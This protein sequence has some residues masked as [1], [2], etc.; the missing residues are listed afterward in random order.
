M[1]LLF[2]L[3]LGLITYFIVQRG[4]ASSTST[5]VWILWLV[6]MTP[7]LAWT[8]WIWVQGEDRAPPLG[9]M[10][11][12]FVFS[13]LLYLYLIQVGRSS[14]PNRE[15]AESEQESKVAPPPAL[16]VEEQRQLEQCFPWS[17]YALH[18]TECKGQVVVCRGQLRTSSDVAYKTVR[19]KIEAHFGD[20]FLIVFQEGFEDKPFFVL[21]PNPQFQAK[22]PQ[23]RLTRPMMALG[24]L[25]LTILT[26]TL[27]GT[28]AFSDLVSPE[29]EENPNLLLENPSLLAPG[30]PYAI[31]LMTILGIHELGHYLMARRYKIKATLPYFI[32]IPFFLGTFGAFIQ[33]RSPIPHRKALFDVGI[34]G[35]LAGL[36]VTIPIFMWGLSQSD[37]I[38]ASENTS[39]FNFDSLNPKA[40]VL[41]A[42]LSK[43]ALGNQLTTDMAVNLHPVAVAGFLGLVITALNLVPVGQLDGGHVVHAMFGQRTAVA[44]GQIS[45]LLVLILAFLHQEFLWWAIFL[46]L[47]PI[48]DEP[49]LN[50]VTELDNVRDFLGLLALVILVMIVLPAPP[51]LIEWFYG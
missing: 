29:V 44:I 40:T 3:L 47:M 7:A 51:T 10:I 32:P 50:D 46:L 31:A 20:R 41:L 6:M 1:T 27:M 28:L 39:M 33:I 23:P 11:A 4:V 9:V 30:L 43:I 49:A 2:L 26:T 24:L 8:V 22:S 5:P 48:A 17:A 45:R 13:S 15:T 21:I 37:V 25:A 19:E 18:E 14:P 34:A 35:P 42:I 38:S 36:M 12:L 16:T